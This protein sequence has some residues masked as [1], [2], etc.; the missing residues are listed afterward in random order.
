MKKEKDMCCIIDG[1]DQSKLLLPCLIQNTKKYAG[2][3]RL[4]THLT[5]TICLQDSNYK[6]TH[7]CKSYLPRTRGYVIYLPGFPSGQYQVNI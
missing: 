3:W 5:G 1:M 4:K 7:C 6:R 2:A